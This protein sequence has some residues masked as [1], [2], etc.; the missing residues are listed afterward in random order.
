MMISIYSIRLILFFILLLYYPV[1]AWSNSDHNEAKFL[2]DSGEIL[3]LQL[4]LDKAHKIYPGK[5]LEVEL[6]TEKQKIV[7]EIE[8][9]LD[10]GHVLE[11]L[12]DAT[13]GQHLSTKKED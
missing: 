6:E 10:N 8:L 5:I 13:T 1:Y 9:L 3:P 11:L 12:F 4:I 7:Y 2:V